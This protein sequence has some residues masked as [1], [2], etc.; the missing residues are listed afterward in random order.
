MTTTQEESS[1]ETTPAKKTKAPV[2][3]LPPSESYAKTATKPEKISPTEKSGL[4]RSISRKPTGF[5]DGTSNIFGQV[6]SQPPS[7]FGT[8]SGTSGLAS[9]MPGTLNFERGFETKRSTA[10]NTVAFGGFGKSSPGGS[11][12]FGSQG[13][14]MTSWSFDFSKNDAAKVQGEKTSIRNA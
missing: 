14:A 10:A 8:T 2:V 3:R 4:F 7:N 9:G 12:A 6:P 1:A 11:N 5:D 13:S